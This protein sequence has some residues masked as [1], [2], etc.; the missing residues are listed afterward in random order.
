MAD[1]TTT[2]MAFFEACEAGKG[3]DA[4]ARYCTPTATFTAQSEP[5]ADVTTLQQYAEWMAWL[6]GV[7]PDGRYDLHAFATDPARAAVSA[8]ATFHGTH[9]G[10]GGPMEPTGKSVSTDY[11][12]LMQFDGNRIAHMTKVWN[13]GWALKQVGWA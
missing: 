12:Y 7:M 1:I 3:W 6:L 9:T 4:C 2:A 11:V 5:L 13:A 10:P 8:V